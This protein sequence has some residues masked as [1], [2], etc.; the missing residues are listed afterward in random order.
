MR[1]SSF[2]QKVVFTKANIN[3]LNLNV[4]EQQGFTDTFKVLGKLRLFFPNINESAKTM[5]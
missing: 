1:L 5:D 4:A 2:F 3:I